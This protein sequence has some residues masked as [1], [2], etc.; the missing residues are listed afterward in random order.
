MHINKLGYT[1]PIFLFITA[2]FHL[3][4][5]FLFVII[6]HLEE[7]LLFYYISFTFIQ[8]KVMLICLNLSQINQFIDLYLSLLCEN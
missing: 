3:E 7:V 8:I 2:A 5:S 4:I 1:S 6:N